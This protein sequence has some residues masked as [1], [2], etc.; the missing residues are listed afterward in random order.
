MPTST[1]TPSELPDSESSSGRLRTF[2]SVGQEL[3]QSYMRDISTYPLLTQEEE[4]VLAKQFD[5][6]RDELQKTIRQFPTLLYH[7]IGEF[8]H[9]TASGRLSNYFSLQNDDAEA[10]GEEGLPPQLQAAWP[11]LTALQTPEH[12]FP[13]NCAL[14]DKGAFWKALAPLKPRHQ[15]FTR[16]LDALDNPECRAAVIP[17]KTWK[18][19]APKLA[20]LRIKMKLAM[21]TL[22]ER[23]LRLVISIAS[24]YTGTG[25]PL[26][27]LVQ[28]GNIGLMRAVERYDH[29]LGHRFTT[30]ASYWIRQ[31]ITRNITN[32]SRIIRMPANTVKQISQIRQ[33][34]Q[35]LLNETGQLPAPEAIASLVGLS[36]AK[37]RALQKMTQQPIS[38]QSILGEDSTLEDIIPDLNH[39]ASSESADREAL[40][41]AITQILDMLD[42]R[43]Q[44]IIRLR[45]GLD[46]GETH[47]LAE[48]S[49]LVNLS[50]ER[51][52]QIEASALQKM[53][54]P[55]ALELLDGYNL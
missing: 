19:L 5:A 45:F 10:L 27:D 2:R 3:Q 30:Y 50:S 13:E 51:V 55:A 38:L 32:Q 22:V 12:T 37:V 11:R 48:I 18:A 28:E 54:M 42:E 20:R 43:E 53:R 47:T 36:P 15:F 24:R 44:N 40:R 1:S 16:C 17:A 31:A 52:R 34:E 9:Q 25:I 14:T 41:E 46:D 23:N 39:Q 7:V 29:R 33:A 8:V 21:S 26:N 4:T 35:H 49:A 6:C